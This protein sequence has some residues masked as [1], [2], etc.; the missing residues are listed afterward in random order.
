MCTDPIS[1]LLTS[2][3]NGLH[4]HKERVNV[5]WSRL[6]EAIIKVA[7][8]EGFLKEYAKVEEQ[9]RP[10]LR[11]WLK[12]D[13]AGKP[14]LRGVK[15]ISKPSLRTYTGTNNIP[16]VQNGLGVNILSTSRGIMA[17]RE[18]RKQHVGGEILCS[19]W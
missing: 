1:D 11:I 6:K 9:G 14:V 7:I 13:A 8:E 3:R 2:V 5:P 18:A 4:A 10:Q 15:R 16:L 12:Y 17:D 19:L